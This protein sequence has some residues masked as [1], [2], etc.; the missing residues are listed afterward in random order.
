MKI[1]KIKDV[2]NSFPYF[3]QGEDREAMAFIPLLAPIYAPDQSVSELVA[4]YICTR[5]RQELERLHGLGEKYVVRAMSEE[6]LRGKVETMSL[7]VVERRF[8]AGPVDADGRQVDE[9]EIEKGN[10]YYVLGENGN[11]SVYFKADYP[12]GRRFEVS[13][14]TGTETDFLENK[15]PFR[16]I[17]G[18]K[19][20]E[21]IPDLRTGFIVRGK[22]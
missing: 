22:L 12:D 14:K 8:W 9:A 4:E 16:T 13:V 3:I 17:F 20:I 21:E 5:S 18:Y 15:D 1:K 10:T 6:G 19:E 11:G 2:D 7:P